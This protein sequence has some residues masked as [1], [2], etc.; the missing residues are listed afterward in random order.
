[1]IETP[2]ARRDLLLVAPS[3]AAAVLSPVD[4]AAKVEKKEKETGAVEDLM[5]EHGVLRRAYLVYG[6]CAKKLRKGDNLDLRALYDTANL[7]RAFGE[8][9]HEHLLE[10]THIFPVVRAAGG[11]ARA[12]IDILLDQHRRGRAITDYILAVTK[13][14][15]IAS[16]EAAA[17][18][19]AFK[20]FQLIYANHTAG[21]DTIVFPAWKN[22]LSDR[23]LSDMGEEFE[24]IERRQFGHDGFEDA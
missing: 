14:G 7:F 23:Q 21:E 13:A 16:A 11:E 10:E 20:S 22:A 4:A 12:Y 24:D 3:L 9:Y 8:D 5:R 19:G 18:A 15:R 2:T 6:E 17:L 1:M